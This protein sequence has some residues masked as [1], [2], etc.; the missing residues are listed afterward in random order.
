[1]REE[2]SNYPRYKPVFDNNGILVFEN[3]EAYPMVYMDQDKNTV[4][5]HKFNINNIE[6]WPR[7]RQE[8]DLVVNVVA[9]DGYSYKIS[10]QGKYIELDVEGQRVEVSPNIEGLIILNITRYCTVYCITVHISLFFLQ[11]CQWL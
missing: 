2:I 3:M 6:I 8:D 11:F 7:N 4:V 1:M 9:M 5:T 10:S